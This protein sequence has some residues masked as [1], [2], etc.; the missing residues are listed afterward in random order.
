MTASYYYKPFSSMLKKKSPLS[1]L[2]SFLLPLCPLSPLLIPPQFRPSLSGPQILLRSSHP[3]SRPHRRRRDAT[4]R[5]PA[6]RPSVRASAVLPQNPCSA[7]RG[8]CRTD[9]RSGRAD[10]P[11]YWFSP[12][13]VSKPY[14]PWGKLR[15][16]GNSF[17]P[18]G[19]FIS[20]LRLRAP[21]SQIFVFSRLSL[22]R[23]I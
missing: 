11:T 16:T 19:S 4:T 8:G 22:L 6:G 20:L 10:W 21:N 15:R 18:A 1:P 3:H 2:F 5:G 13:P 9:A 23:L 17:P 14:S 12:S 7:G